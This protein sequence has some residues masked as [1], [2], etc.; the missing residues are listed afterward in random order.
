MAAV[1]VIAQAGSR[2]FPT[3]AARIRV[4]SG[5]VGFEVDKVAGFL[6]VLRFPL[7]IIIPPN[8]PSS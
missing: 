7:L 3:A 5:H 2:W 4:R 8:F 6:Q 1:S